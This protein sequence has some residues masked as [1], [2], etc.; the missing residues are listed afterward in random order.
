[1][2]VCVGRGGDG[3]DAKCR[4]SVIDKMAGSGNGGSANVDVDGMAYY[5]HW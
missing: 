2:C 3:E 1:M 4:G 5:G